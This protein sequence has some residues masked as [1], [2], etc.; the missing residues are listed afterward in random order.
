M[1]KVVDKQAI[2]G[3]QQTVFD[4]TKTTTKEPKFA[5]CSTLFVVSGFSF[6]SSHDSQDSKESGRLFL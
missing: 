5:I 4:E 1:F 6:I 3:I 2:V